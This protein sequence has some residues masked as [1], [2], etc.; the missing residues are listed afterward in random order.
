M[1]CLQPMTIGSILIGSLSYTLALNGDNNYLYR[2]S[3]AEG[4]R[5]AAF[6]GDVQVSVR[7]AEA[8]LPYTSEWL[9]PRGGNWDVRLSV[10][11][12]LRRVEQ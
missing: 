6:L 5:V 7:R 1:L 10:D 9:L 2:S 4:D 3:L 11:M 8:G 12:H